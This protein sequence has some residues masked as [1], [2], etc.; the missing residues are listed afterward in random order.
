MVYID[1]FSDFLLVFFFDGISFES[2][3]TDYTDFTISESTGYYIVPSLDFVEK[4][5]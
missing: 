2:L 3:N 1:E 5:A 4:N